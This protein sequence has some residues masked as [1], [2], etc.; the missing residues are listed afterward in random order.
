MRRLRIIQ[1]LGCLVA[2]ALTAGA[3]SACH[4]G[5]G[6]ASEQGMIGEKGPAYTKD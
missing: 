1:L 4:S 6:S 5:S 2:M 3:L